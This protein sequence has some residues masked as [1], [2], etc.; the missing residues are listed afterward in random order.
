MENNNDVYIE[1]DDNENENDNKNE[2][3]TFYRCKQGCMY[4]HPW[5]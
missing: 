2:K 5:H 1:K 4:C 3:K